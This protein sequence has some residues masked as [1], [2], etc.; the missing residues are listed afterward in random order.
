MKPFEYVI[1]AEAT[2][3]AELDVGII[4]EIDEAPDAFCPVKVAWLLGNDTMDSEPDELIV[5]PKIY[6]DELLKHLKDQVP[7]A[8]WEVAL[9]GASTHLR[10]AN[11]ARQQMR[12]GT[13]PPDEDPLDYINEQRKLAQE[14]LRK[15]VPIG[16]NEELNL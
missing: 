2:T 12:D 5:I 11:F 4:Q 10:R 13:W 16:A 8:R 1:N 7:P 6:A 3:P 15:A 14:E 9:V